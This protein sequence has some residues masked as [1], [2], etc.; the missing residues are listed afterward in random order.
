MFEFIS[1]WLNRRIIQR[2]SIAEKQWSEAI[3][4]LPLLQGL[5]DKDLKRLKELS[6]LFIDAKEFEGAGG[7]FSC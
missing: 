6:I 3:L 1:H 7:L 5:K 4:L 2:S